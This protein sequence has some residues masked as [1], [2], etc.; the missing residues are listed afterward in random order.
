MSDNHPSI[1][2][3]MSLMKGWKA[4]TV[5][6]APQQLVWEQ[7]TNFEAYS[8]W[9]PFVIKAYA[10]F[11][12]GAKISFLEDL[13]KFGQHWLNAQFL[14]IDPPYSFVWQGHFA[15]TFLFTVRHSFIFE[16]INEY[17][18]RFT[19]VHENS[20]LLIPYLAWRGVYVV[21]HQGYLNY[22]QALKERCED[23]VANS[24]QT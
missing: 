16:A 18:T 4:E 13:Q 14:S 11:K 21:S 5:I 20:G 24:S 19:Q 9:N 23:I 1:K 22:N 8:D 3:K 6:N 17:Q 2:Q 12:I 15:A 10:D 7:V